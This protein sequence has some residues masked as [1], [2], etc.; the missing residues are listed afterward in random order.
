MSNL[1]EK[2]M[3][4]EILEGVGKNTAAWYSVDNWQPLICGVYSYRELKGSNDERQ[5]VLVGGEPTCVNFT[6]TT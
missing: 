1:L 6:S 5:V 2:Q 4:V 3:E